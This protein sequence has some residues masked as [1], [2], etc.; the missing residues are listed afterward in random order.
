MSNSY[1]NREATN[2]RAWKSELA[3]SDMKCFLQS[4]VRPEFGGKNLSVPKVFAHISLEKITCGA[5]SISDSMSFRRFMLK[6]FIW[7]KPGH[8]LLESVTYK[9]ILPLLPWVTFLVLLSHV[10]I[11]TFAK[12]LT[13]NYV[14]W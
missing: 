1:L 7:S 4:W 2:S 9:V 3:F 5:V 10:I 11:G 13:L 14:G 8:C 12:L 6:K